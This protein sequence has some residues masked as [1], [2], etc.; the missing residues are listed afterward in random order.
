MPKIEYP[1]PPLADDAMALRA[2]REE[3]IAAIT[4]ACQDPLIVRYTYVPYPYGEQDARDWLRLAERQRREGSALGFVVADRDSDR[5]IA[6]VGVNAINWRDRVAQIGYWVA[7]EARRQ[8]VASRSVRMLSRWALDELGLARVEIRVDVENR[9]SQVVAE[10]A[11]FT[12]EGVLRSRGESKGR[13][14]DEVMFSL[15]PSDLERR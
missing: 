1:D 9:A 15:L 13:R 5:V 3:D 4:A 14:W 12:R 8:G 6:S 7:P 10:A 2:P 11:G